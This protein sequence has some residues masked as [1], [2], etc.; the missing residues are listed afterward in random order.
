MVGLTRKQSL[1]QG[2]VT[3]SNMLI[4]QRFLKG[5][6]LKN[7]HFFRPVLGRIR[8]WR[9][10]PPRRYS[11]A[12]RAESGPRFSVRRQFVCRQITSLQVTEPGLIRRNRCAERSKARGQNFNAFEIGMRS[13]KRTIELPLYSIDCRIRTHDKSLT[14]SHTIKA[15]LGDGS[16]YRRFDLS[17]LTKCED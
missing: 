12:K 4:Q 5:C 9:R 14:C 11:R 6:G 1:V 10:R 8:G 16:C 3:N 17:R 2:K 7:P 13:V 15:T